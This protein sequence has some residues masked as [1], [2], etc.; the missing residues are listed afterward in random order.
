MAPSFRSRRRRANCQSLGGGNGRELLREGLVFR[1]RLPLKLG[2]GLYGVGNLF[3][4][5]ERSKFGN[6]VTFGAIRNRDV[7][8]LHDLPLTTFANASF[9]VLHV[10]AR[11]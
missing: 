7:R 11:V 9:A 3:E 2:A 6:R 10:T 4:R 1:R 5:H 8:E